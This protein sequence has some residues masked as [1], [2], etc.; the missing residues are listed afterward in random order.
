MQGIASLELT[1]APLQCFALLIF[2]LP[3]LHILQG[4]WWRQR[5][6]PF[7]GGKMLST[8]AHHAST[9]MLSAGRRSWRAWQPW[10]PFTGPHW[11][12]LACSESPFFIFANTKQAA[13]R[14]FTISTS[15]LWSLPLLT[16][17]DLDHLISIVISGIMT[18]LHIPVQLNSDLQNS[19]STWVCAV[20]SI[21]D[22]EL[23][24]FTV[25]SLIYTSSFTI[26]TWQLVPLKP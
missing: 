6:N 25:S 15:P 22:L 19:W 16:H 1:L 9:L 17:G 8:A 3:T 23:I 24:G 4:P 11:S 26:D 18:C 14:H 13:T 5:G 20:L 21:G 2:L 7:V 10:V 12:I